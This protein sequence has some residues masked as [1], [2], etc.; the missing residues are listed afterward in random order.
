[1]P[2]RCDELDERR[3]DIPV[4]ADRI[5]RKH[6]RR[7]LPMI[8]R[9]GRADLL[10]HRRSLALHDTVL[11]RDHAHGMVARHH[12]EAVRIRLLHILRKRGQRAVRIPVHAQMPL[13]GRIL[14]HRLR[15]LRHDLL[16]RIAHLLE[17]HL[18]GSVVRGCIEEMHDRPVIL[19]ILDD[20]RRILEENMIVD[21]QP[22]TRRALGTELR[23]IHI[24]IEAIGRN[25]VLQTAPVHAAAIPEHRPIAELTQLH[26]QRGRHRPLPEIAALIELQPRV[27]DAGQ[28]AHQ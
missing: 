5:A 15:R 1:M 23:R 28:Q 18:V 19:R 4:A 24:D 13:P 2:G 6:I 11:K 27:I 9:K 14:L 25:V 12:D 20:A 16:R 17:R 7:E 21:P 22:G 3:E 8:H 10:A 26:R